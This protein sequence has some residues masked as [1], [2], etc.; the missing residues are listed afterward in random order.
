M[1]TVLSQ[2]HNNAL[3]ADGVSLVTAT[4][5]AANARR[6]MIYDSATL[7]AVAPV[8][9]HPLTPGRYLMVFSRRWHTATG[10]TVDPGAYSAYSEDTDPGWAIIEGAG[11]R[12]VPGLT[13]SIPGP[14]GRTLTAACSRGN[15]YLYLLST[16]GPNAVVQHFRWSPERDRVTEIAQEVI[17]AVEADE[18]A[19]VFNRGIY[20][21]GQFLTVIG[22]G[23]TDDKIYL[24]RK[25]WGRVGVNRVSA[26]G[27]TTI[28][29]EVNDPR[30]RYRTVSGWST[31]PEESAPLLPLITVGP[32]SVAAFR[33]QLWWATVLADGDDRAAQVWTSR[34]GGEWSLVS[35]PVPL[36]SVA[37]DTYLGG[38]LQFQ[39]HLLANPD[40]VSLTGA[41]GIPFLIS[42]R[43]V[44]G[45]DE[46]IAVPWGLW[47]VVSP[48]VSKVSFG[49]VFAPRIAMAGSGTS[50]GDFVLT[51]TP[52]IGMVGEGISTA[53]FGLSLTPQIAMAAVGTSTAVLSLALTPQIAMAGDPFGNTYSAAFG[54][55]LTPQITMVGEG[56]SEA[57]FALTLTPQI[58]MIGNVPLSIVG[59]PAAVQGSSIPLPTHAI[60]DII[61]I[62]AYR[63]NSTTI[64]SKPSE[65]ETTPAWQDIDAATG[66]NSNS[67]RTAYF[68]ADATNHTSGTWTN[69]TEMAVIVYRGQK[70]VSPIG[71]HAE[72]GGTSASDAVAP[73][74]TLTQNNGSSALI[75]FF[76]HSA[77]DETWNAAPSGY[78]QRASEALGTSGVCLD[79]KNVTTTDGS[80]TQGCATTGTGSYRGATVEILD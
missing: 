44:D 15:D 75:H 72:S 16:L 24:A 55:S 66:A 13:Y 60:D 31:D 45:L 1:G 56:V 6:G 18:Q 27:G 17:A 39:Q 48:Q 73:A 62:Y 52:E 40:K 79:T 12:S 47:S 67:S 22:S 49:L 19:V 7:A 61:V 35:D 11:T 4:R 77:V 76:G 64:P 9:F 8:Y 71:G 2:A 14:A 37:D 28:A 36:G 50:G 21:D 34:K 26:R 41:A 65:S 59:T 68:V 29:T 5:A 42:A 51:L 63:A 20:L 33:D 70:S 32:V 57:A 23:D 25:P 53:S 74:V 43:Q 80:V 3:D 38:T 46:K 78:T 30:W 10:S 58:G 69:A 54:L